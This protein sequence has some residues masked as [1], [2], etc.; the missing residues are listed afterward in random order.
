M[1]CHIHYHLF[2][3]VNEHKS[4]RGDCRVSLTIELLSIRA[5]VGMPEVCRAQTIGNQSRRW[6]HMHSMLLLGP[7]PSLSWSVNFEMLNNTYNSLINTK[8]QTSTI[9]TQLL[10]WIPSPGSSVLARHSGHCMVL[11]HF[12]DLC[13]SCRHSSQ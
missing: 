13:S 6:L 4:S 10:P 8:D 12:D 9:T 11:V 7:G 3:F 2:Q 5:L 1:F